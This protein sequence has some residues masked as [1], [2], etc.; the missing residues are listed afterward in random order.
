[1]S[2]NTFALSP[3][4]NSQARQEEVLVT[5]QST[6]VVLTDAIPP[7]AK[8][9]T[10][11]TT[12]EIFVQL[13]EGTEFFGE[14]TL[15]TIPDQLSLLARTYSEDLGDRML[16]LEFITND[17]PVRY[18]LE[19]TAVRLCLDVDADRDGIV[20]DNNPA[21]Q[22]WQ[23][24]P[25]G[26][27]AIFI[28]NSD[29]DID[30]SDAKTNL[31][32]RR[33][34]GLLDL[35]DLALLVVRKMGVG[36]LPRGYELRLTVNNASRDR[37][38]IFEDLDSFSG[39]E[40]IGPGRND[41]RIIPRDTQ[42]DLVLGLEGLNYRDRDFDGLVE[43]SLTL[44][45]DGKPYS[46]DW[47]RLGVA[48]WIMTPNTLNPRIVYIAQTENNRPTIN[49]LRPVVGR[50]GAQLEE[51]Q[52]DLNLGDRWLQDELEIGYTQIPGQRHYVALESPRYRGLEDFPESLLGPDFGHVT[53]GSINQ[54]TKLDS[55]GNLEVSPPVTVNG[56]DYPLGRILYGDTDETIA[57]ADRRRFQAALRDFLV[58]QQVQAP[59]QLFSDWLNVGHIDEFMT[60]V[61][62]PT[63]KGFKLVLA[64][65]NTCYQ[66]LQDLQDKGWGDLRLRKGKTLGGESAAIAIKDVLANETLKASNDRF[67]GFIDQNRVILREALGLAADDFIELPMLFKGY[68][69]SDATTERADSF[70][71]NMV[72]MIVLGAQLAIPKPFGPKLNGVCQLEAAVRSQLEPLG[73][74]CH[75]IDD[76]DAY[77]SAFGELHCGTNVVRQPFA[78]PW[79]EGLQP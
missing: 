76:W 49:A 71:P 38:R 61:P 33:I 25:E 40:L 14:T 5:G 56:E 70:F 77:F 53:R 9:L 52:P 7:R 69:L 39:R 24:G 35:K 1:M 45:R 78:H 18:T 17:R 65:P 3:T 11:R 41:V 64:S 21:K 44:E 36:N 63:P 67:Q 27:G 26:Q 12:G 19:L 51:V 46:R 58:A 30:Y 66:L 20:D 34:D 79:W 54:R 55:F 10:L 15:E 6:T 32:N 29:Q 59:V 42:R 2:L 22:D 47:A 68:T 60:F 57:P 13:P 73:L 62:A 50:S 48:P 72:N 75:F 16:N 31:Q 43:I 74:T 37:V 28:V 8:C 23:W 4:S